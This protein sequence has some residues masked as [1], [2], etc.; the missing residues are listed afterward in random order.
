MSDAKFSVGPVGLNLGEAK[1]D[2]GF[3]IPVTSARPTASPSSTP[4]GSLVAMWINSIIKIVNYI[5]LLE[6]NSTFH[7]LRGA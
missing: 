4:N 5:L 7:N 3:L 2:S 6:H 1:R